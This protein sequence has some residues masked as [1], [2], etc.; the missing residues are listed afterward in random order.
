MTDIVVAEALGESLS[1]SQVNTY[2]TCPAKWYFRYLIGLSEP[3]TE[4]LALGK[5]FHGTPARTF[6]PKLRTGHDMEA[7]ELR[8]AFCQEWWSVIADAAWHNDENA[9]E[10]AA[11]GQVLAAAY[12]QK[13]LLP[14][15]HGQSSNP[16]R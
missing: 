3:T 10:L 1:P 16:S 12:L 2:I 13:L 14:R 15:S 7:E 4:A 9:D 5:T 6:R 11:T 8:E